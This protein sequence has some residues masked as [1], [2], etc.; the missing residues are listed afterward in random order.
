MSAPELRQVAFGAI[1]TAIRE[2]AM[3]LIENVSADFAAMRYRQ[4][5]IAG[6]KQA[7]D[8]VADAYKKLGHGD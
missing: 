5:E 7:R 1:D 2:S 3:N 4:G 8:L 6:L